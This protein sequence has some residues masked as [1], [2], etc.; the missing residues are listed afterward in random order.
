M[1]GSNV[2]ARPEPDAETCLQGAGSAPRV[3]RTYR[4]YLDWD[5][6]ALIGSSSVALAAGLSDQRCKWLDTPTGWLAGKGR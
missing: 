3:A 4:A 1:S 6:S 2:G 5:G